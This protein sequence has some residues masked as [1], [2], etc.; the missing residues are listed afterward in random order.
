M[1]SPQLVAMNAD[2]LIRLRNPGDFHATEDAYLSRPGGQI[3]QRRVQTKQ[4]VK[5]PS[6]H[7][8]CYSGLLLL[9]IGSTPRKLDRGATDKWGSIAGKLDRIKTDRAID[10]TFRHAD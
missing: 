10:D 4:T 8:F 3:G 9:L 1:C 2:G 5:V 6:L 7:G